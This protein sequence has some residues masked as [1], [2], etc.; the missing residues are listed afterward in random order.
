[1]ALSDQKTERFYQDIFTLTSRPEWNTLVEYL[2]EVLQVKKDNALDLETIE[3]LYKEKGQAE[4]LRM[5]ISFRD[6][7]ESQYQ[8][9]EGEDLSQ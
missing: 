2:N 1:M 5:I 3:D 8:F 6:V 9:L 4:I 7:A